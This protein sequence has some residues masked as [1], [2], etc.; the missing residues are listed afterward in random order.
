M[1][2]TSMPSAAGAADHRSQPRRR[3]EELYAFLMH[4]AP[5]PEE[6]LTGIVDNVLL[7]LLTSPA[8]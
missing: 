3:G 6:V 7:P 8:A 2:T 5:V 1:G 4:G